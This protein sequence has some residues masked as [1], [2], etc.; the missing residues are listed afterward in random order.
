MSSN[1]FCFHGSGFVLGFS[2]DKLVFARPSH[3]HK[4]YLDKHFHNY[5]VTTVKHR[6]A[7]LNMT[8]K[9]VA[10]AIKDGRFVVVEDLKEKLQ[11]KLALGEEW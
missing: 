7:M 8:S 2:Y 4:T 11:L 5:S 9:E 1:M 10:Q 6:N 3:D